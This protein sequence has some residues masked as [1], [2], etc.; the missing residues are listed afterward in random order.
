MESEEKIRQDIDKYKTKAIEN[1][2]KNIVGIS[3][4]CDTEELIKT[5]FQFK[6]DAISLYNE[7]FKTHPDTFNNTEY[8]SWYN[9]AK[10]EIEDKMD[11]SEMNKIDEINTKA[12]LLCKDILNREYEQIQNKIS[13]GVYNSKNCEEYIKDYEQFINAYNE[14]AKGDNKLKIFIDFISEKK[15]EFIKS[16]TANLNVENKAKMEELNKKLAES[17]E[18]KK[19][20]EEEFRN[21]ND[22]T[23]ENS[24]KIDDLNSEIEK[25]KREIKN[26]NEQIEGIEEEIKKERAMENQ[27]TNV[28]NNNPKA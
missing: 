20:A 27:N 22:K 19:R 5:I 17:N 7:I 3:E 21:V 11:N 15:S 9:D 14:Q 10:R 25:K 28:D 18:A 8:L 26:L 1:F 12:N 4:I 16:F 24:K 6:L 2:N 23:E 13:N